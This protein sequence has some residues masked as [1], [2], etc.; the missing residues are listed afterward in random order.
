MEFIRNLKDRPLKRL[1][2]KTKDY[3]L[4]HD[5]SK[6]DET[7][8]GKYLDITLYSIIHITKY[9]DRAIQEEDEPK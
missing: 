8:M 6:D 2:Q 1:I 5:W 7:M 4:V 9:K 3:R